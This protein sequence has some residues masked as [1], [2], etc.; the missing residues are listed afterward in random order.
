MTQRLHFAVLFLLFLAHPAWSAEPE[1]QVNVEKRGELFVVD[2]TF[3]LAVPLRTAWGVF[4]DF[5]NMTRILSNLTSSK[6]TS[7]TGNLLQVQQEGVAKFGF[8]SYTFTSEREIQ[9][10]PMKKILAKQLSGNAKQFN[11]ELELSRQG[12]GTKVRYHAEMSLESMI[13]RTF[14]GSF[15]E[16]EIA[17]QF[18]AMAA[19]MNRRTAQ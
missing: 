13:A 17:E 14:G 3:E 7:R 12:S 5:D 10:M 2:S 19:E 15:I 4:T 1:I 18:A 16:H 11:S 9:L 8:F 6:I